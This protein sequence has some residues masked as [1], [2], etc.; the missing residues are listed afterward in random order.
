MVSMTI[1][2]PEEI[3]LVIEACD[4]LSE[5]CYHCAQKQTLINLACAWAF[6]L[7]MTS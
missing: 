6:D 1:F 3:S 5:H 2:T 7:G 4:D